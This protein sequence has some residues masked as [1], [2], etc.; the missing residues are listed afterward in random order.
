MTSHA[1]RTARGAHVHL[2]VV[3]EEVAALHQLAAHAPRQEAVLEVGGVVRPGRRAPRCAAAPLHR[4]PP[5]PSPRGARAGYSSTG[6]TGVL[7]NAWGWTRFIT[8]RF[9]STYDTPDGVRRLSSSTT[10]LPSLRRIRSMP[11]TWTYTPPGGVTPRMDGMYP[12]E[13]SSI[14]RGSTPLLEDALRS[15]DVGE[16]QVERLDALLET[17]REPGPLEGADDPRDRV[18]GKDPLHAACRR[19][20]PRR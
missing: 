19:S 4:A 2:L 18:E 13:A 6:C 8:V 14:S 5:T 12:R 16:V 1:R 7:R 15:V 3:H 20:R 9:S 17:A 11:A 10:K